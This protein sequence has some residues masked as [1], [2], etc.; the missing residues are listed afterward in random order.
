MKKTVKDLTDIQG[1]RVL[2]RVD[3]NV[4]LDEKQ[5]I[6]DDIRIKA[7]LPTVNYLREKGAK[8]IL[9]SHLGRPKGQVKDSLRLNPVAKRLSEL[10]NAPVLK[11]DDC[12]G[13]EVK[14]KIN[15]MTD[16]EVALLENIRFYAQEEKNDPEFAKKLC[17]LADV[18]VNDA[19]GAAHRAHASTEGVTKCL[20]PSVA[21]FLMEKE[22]SMLGKLLENPVR[23]FV[24]IIGGS[25]T[26]VC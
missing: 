17:E 21:G 1:K 10:I 18:Y 15:A 11:L 8:V 2:V 7:A 12:I 14:A 9:V 20:H 24:A 6:T 22:I 13:D 23:P 3:F 26:M 19:F 25:K 5:N 4:P 16:G